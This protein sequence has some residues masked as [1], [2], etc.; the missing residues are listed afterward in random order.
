MFN[1]SHENRLIKVIEEENDR[2]YKE[3]EEE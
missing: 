2:F 1:T 3:I